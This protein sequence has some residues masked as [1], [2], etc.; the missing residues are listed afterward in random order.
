MSTRTPPQDAA[1]E[2]RD[3]LDL[4]AWYRSW[5]EGTESLQDKAERLAIA[6]R[7]EAQARTLGSGD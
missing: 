1:R 7:L 2:A 4:A 5:A 6:D 3:L